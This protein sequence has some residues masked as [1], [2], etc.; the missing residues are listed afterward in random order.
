MQDYDI[1]ILTDQRYETPD[2]TNWY[3]AQLLGEERLLMAGLEARG[4]SLDVGLL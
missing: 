1:I 4:V 3:Q 2:E